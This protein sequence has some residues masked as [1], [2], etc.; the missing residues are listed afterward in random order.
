MKKLLAM[1]SL[2]LAFTAH[3]GTDSPEGLWQTIDDETGKPKSHVQIWI[4]E[5]ELKG[6][7]VKL[8]DPEEENP[9][10]SECEGEKKDQPIVGMQFI[11]GLTQE[12]GVWDDGTIL[13]P[14]SGSEY[15]SKIEVV[16]GGQKL[17][18]RGY[19]GF[20]WA[21]RSQT[22]ERIEVP[23]ES[24]QAEENVQVSTTAE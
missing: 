4:D 5:G 13:D 8:I 3:A 12:D 6:K 1:S 20:S 11:W 14:A 17:D 24:A 16:D 7:I 10:C 9:V 22:W 23:A 2:L 15:T 19:I 21:G 18:V